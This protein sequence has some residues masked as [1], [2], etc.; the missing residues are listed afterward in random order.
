ML[1]CKFLRLDRGLSLKQTA[2][3]THKRPSTSEICLIE[4][5]RLIPTPEQR[6]AL[7]RVLKCDPDRLTAHVTGATLETGAES[8]DQQEQGK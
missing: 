3:L 1:F 8:R 2:I 7:A 5:G 4:L 6:A